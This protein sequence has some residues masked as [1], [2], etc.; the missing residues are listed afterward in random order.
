MHYKGIIYTCEEI[1]SRSWFNASS[2]ERK[3][4]AIKYLNTYFKEYKVGEI[5]KEILKIEGLFKDSSFVVG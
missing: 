5:R 3:M 1:I 2:W 4:G